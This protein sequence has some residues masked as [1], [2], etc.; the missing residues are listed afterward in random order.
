MYK[1]GDFMTAEP[2]TLNEDDDLGHADTVLRLGRIRHLPVVRGEKL[3]GLVTHRDILRVL[4]K[5]APPWGRSTLAADVMTREL[6]TVGRETPLRKAARVMLKHKLG[7]LPVVEANG[8]LV[9][10]LTEADLV[11]FAADMVGDL[12]RVDEAVAHME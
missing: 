11:R 3:V 9:G 2:V 7:C 8:R 1:V 6:T 5:N 10:I 4:G 12:D